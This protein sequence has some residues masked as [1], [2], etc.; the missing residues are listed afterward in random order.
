MNCCSPISRKDF[1]DTKLANFRA[2]IE[3]HCTTGELKERYEEFKT[4]DAVMPYLLQC[5]VVSKAG[6]LDS[7]V[8]AFCAQFPA[9]VSKDEAFRTKLRR[10]F[11][12]FVEVL[13]S[14]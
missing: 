12:M 7:A 9:E 11:A 1:L 10:Y 2:F 4:L 3:P 14:P 6:Q 13:T 8:E 5:V